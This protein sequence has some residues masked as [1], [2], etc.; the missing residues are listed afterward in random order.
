MRLECDLN[1]TWGRAEAGFSGSPLAERA[2]WM[3]VADP[4]PGTIGRLP[5]RWR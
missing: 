4:D 3:T 1:A 2:R 5:S